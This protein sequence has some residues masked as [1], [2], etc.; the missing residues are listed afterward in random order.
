AAAVPRTPACPRTARASEVLVVV[1]LCDL[2]GG[3]SANEA[4][5]AV[6]LLRPLRERRA[7]LQNAEIVDEQLAMQMI[8]LVLAATGEQ[9][10]RGELDRLPVAIDCA[11]HDLRRAL[12]VPED[13]RDRQ[14]TLLRLRAALG[15]HDLGVHERDGK[16][17]AVDVDHGDALETSDLW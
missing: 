8:D 10:G 5:V 9:L 15:R 12:D 7:A 4:R 17:P 6:S 1:V 16:L 11:D 2:F 13:V 3:E 14:A